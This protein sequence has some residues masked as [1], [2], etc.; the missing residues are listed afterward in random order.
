MNTTEPSWDLYRTFL[1]VVREGS[2]SGAARSLG[3][4][5]PTVARHIDALEDSIGAE[6]FVRSQR[7]LS[8]NEI[9]LELQPYAESLAATAAAMLR[10][11]SAGGDRVRG[12]VRLSASEVV[13]I[14]VLPPI[15]AALRERHPELAVELITSNELDNLLRR[16]ADIAV[17]MVE[18]TQES[19]VVKRIGAISLGLFAH[20]DYLERRGVPRRLADLDDHDIIGFDRETPAIRA[21]RR[22]L[23]GFE[24]ERFAFRADNQVA[25]LAAMRAGFGIGICQVPLAA[26][27]PELVRLM[28]DVIDLELPTWLAMH[29]NL[30]STPRCRAAF[31]A[32][33]EG[34]QAYVDA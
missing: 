29:E 16:D 23:P 1:A 2:L 5:Q 20:P 3:L 14:E 4:T 33:C 31:D 34:L 11:A 15:L 17:R 28:P 13:G 19:L 7:G 32:L 22:K 27:V 25:Q 8:P 30:R 21:M 9:A 26:R 12:T 24:R 10:A 6:L 18:P